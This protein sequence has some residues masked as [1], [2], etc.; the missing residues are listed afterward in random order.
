MTSWY[1]N[2]SRKG[3]NASLNFRGPQWSTKLHWT[4]LID[5]TKLF[6]NVIFLVSSSS[7]VISMITVVTCFPLQCYPLLSQR[8]Y[9]TTLGKI[10]GS[11]CALILLICFELRH[12]PIGNVPYNNQNTTQIEHIDSHNTSHNTVSITT[13]WRVSALKFPPTKSQQS[14]VQSE[15]YF[16]IQ[17]K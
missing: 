16:H 12:F 13:T 8:N 7:S 6:N 3:D 15:S 17:L 5:H 11:W 1:H 10:D 9:V 14:I 2:C 4:F